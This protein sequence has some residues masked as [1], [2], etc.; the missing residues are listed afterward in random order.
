MDNR[1]A[2]FVGSLGVRRFMGMKEHNIDLP[3]IMDCGK[4]LFVNLGASGFLDRKAAMV[5]ASLFLYEFMDTAMRRAV[6]AQGSGEKPSLYPLYLDEF[7]NYITDDIAEALDQA[8]KGGLH[9]VLAHQ[10]LG[11]FAD[12]PKLRKSVFTNARL[13]AVFGGLDY[14]DACVIGNEMFLP[15]LNTRQ[16]KKGLLPHHPYLLRTDPNHPLTLSH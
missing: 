2:R 5:F 7:Q 10:H 8:L 9:M 4:I 12:N 1:L 6:R 16:I 15:D 3:D 11:H 14:E 13:R